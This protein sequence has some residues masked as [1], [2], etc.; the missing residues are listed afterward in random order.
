MKM[1]SCDGRTAQVLVGFLYVRA[2]RYLTPDRSISS[3][4]ERIRKT[5]SFWIRIERPWRER[6]SYTSY[7]G[8]NGP[9]GSSLRNKFTTPIKGLSSDS[10]VKTCT[11]TGCTQFVCVFYKIAIVK[12]ISDCGPRE[13]EESAFSEATESAATEIPTASLSDIKGTTL[14]QHFDHFFILLKNTFMRISFCSSKMTEITTM[15]F[16]SPIFILPVTTLLIFIKTLCIKNIL[17]K[18]L[19]LRKSTIF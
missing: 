14:A 8:E 7:Y 13:I 1:C 5:Y 12:F 2:T 17:A 11:S 18:I 16:H 4:R 19:S 3:Q 10:M 15:H 9:L 6:G